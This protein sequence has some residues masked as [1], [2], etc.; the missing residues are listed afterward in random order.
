MLHGELQAFPVHVEQFAAE[1]ADDQGRSCSW[2]RTDYT[3]D[4]G[5]NKERDATNDLKHAEIIL[6]KLGPFQRCRMACPTS[7]STQRTWR[8]GLSE[9][10]CPPHHRTTC[11][12]IA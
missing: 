1:T 4:D 7:S 6:E 8:P 10:L 9:F 5:A 3:T 2:D 12:Q 11:P